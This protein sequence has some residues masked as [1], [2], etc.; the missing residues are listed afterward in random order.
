MVVAAGWLVA[1]AAAWLMVVAAG[2]LAL[3]RRCRQ[4]LRDA[5]GVL[6][7]VTGRVECYTPQA[8]G[9]AAGNSGRRGVVSQRGGG[10]EF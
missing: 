10:E 7:N 1:M 8:S 3:V 9:P 5:A 2:W 6:Y 4:G